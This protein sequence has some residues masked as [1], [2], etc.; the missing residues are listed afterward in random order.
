MLGSST[1]GSD[2][3]QLAAFDGDVQHLLQQQSKPP[4]PTAAAASRRSQAAAVAAAPAPAAE[5]PSRIREQQLR[6]A[7]AAPAVVA[8]IRPQAPST[9]KSIAEADS[10]VAGVIDQAIDGAADGAVEGNTEL[11]VRECNADSA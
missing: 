4:P 8:G 7:S 6:H 2:L 10:A 3:E 9:L 11:E 5:Q 1:A